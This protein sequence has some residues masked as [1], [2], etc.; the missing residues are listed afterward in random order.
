MTK[1]AAA[2]IFG[3]FLLTFGAVGGMENPDQVDYFI[4]QVA[5]AVA[6][7]FFMFV[8]TALLPKEDV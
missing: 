7:L 4:E 5:A 6:G 8:G 1:L 2:F 3:G